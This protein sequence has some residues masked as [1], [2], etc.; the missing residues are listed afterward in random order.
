MTTSEVRTVEANFSP[1]PNSGYHQCWY[2][3]ATSST[4]VRGEVLG[5]DLCDG[6]IVVYRT[7]GGDVHAMAPH[8]RHMGAD[9]SI[10][11]V[12]DDQVRCPFHHWHYGP[13]GHC[14]KIPSGDRIPRQARLQT[15]PVADKWGL[16]WVFW[17]KEALYP[18]PSFE[19]WDDATMMLH[20]F[21]ADLAESIKVDPWVF[22]SNVFDIVHNRVVHGLQ[23]ADPEVQIVDA[24]TAR[25]HWDSEY[26]ERESGSMR[27]DLDV[28]GTNVIRTCGEHDGRMTWHIAGVSPLG[29]RG[30]RVFIVLATRRDTGAREH[31]ERQAALHNRFVNEDLPILN[32]MRLGDFQLVGNDRAIARYFRF[33]RN[34]PRATMSELETLDPPRV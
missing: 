23:I 13:D 2:P 17:G 31:L 25:M 24:F 6:R 33:A 8:C 12:V 34:Y 22:A 5:T 28:Y 30:T 9:L 21:E 11:D 15:F 4:L 1:L 27:A 29:R 14:T 32:S 26:V 3:V 20:A 19:A 18:V 16:I 10:G 7:E